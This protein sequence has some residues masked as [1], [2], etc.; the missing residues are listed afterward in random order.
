MVD[1]FILNKGSVLQGYDSYIDDVVIGNKIK[2]ENIIGEFNSI[3]VVKITATRNANNYNS[4]RDLVKG[5]TDASEK[6]IYEIFIPDGEW[7]EFDL[8]GKNTLN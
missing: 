7:F 8:Q 1:T 2:A 3:E 4:I 6:K 5:I